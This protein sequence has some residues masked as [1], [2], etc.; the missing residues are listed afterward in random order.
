MIWQKMSIFVILS[1]YNKDFLWNDQMI[2]GGQIHGSIPSISNFMNQNEELC[3]S[4]KL[5]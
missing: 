4:Q 2:D 5:F 3:K 1:L